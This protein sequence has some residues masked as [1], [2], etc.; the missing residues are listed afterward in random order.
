MPRPAPD[1]YAQYYQKYVSQLPEENILAA[2]EADYEPTLKFLRSITEAQSLEVHAPY[3][4]TFREVLGHILDGERVFTFRALW[5]AR[6]DQRPQ[7]GFDE[8]DFDKHAEYKR[9]SFADLVEEFAHLRRATIYFFKSLP[10]AA[11]SRRGIASDHPVSVNAL[12]YMTIGHGRHHF[13][14]MKQRLTSIG[15]NAAV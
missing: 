3:T 1:E 14:I 8:M 10:A 13:K 4:W 9:I 7:Y 15:V 2:Y 11:W 12:A 6:G 5:F